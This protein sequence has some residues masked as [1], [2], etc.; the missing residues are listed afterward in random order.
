VSTAHNNTHGA[1]FFFRKGFGDTIH[2]HE[3]IEAE[4]LKFVDDAFKVKMEQLFK[5]TV[6][7]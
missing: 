5:T 1:A 3:K 7:P 2:R 4:H 6:Q